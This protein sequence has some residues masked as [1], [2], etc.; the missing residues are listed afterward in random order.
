MQ[1]S[2][3]K[4][5]KSKKKQNSENG[6]FHVKCW[7]MSC[8]MCENAFAVCNNMVWLHDMPMPDG[9]LNYHEAINQSDI[10]RCKLHKDISCRC[11]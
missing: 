11:V 3:E 5:E 7:R 10:P 6:V 1:K 9:T 4:R 2:V 8:E